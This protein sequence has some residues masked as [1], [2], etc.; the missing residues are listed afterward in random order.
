MSRT[1][2]GLVAVLAL[3]L[4]A[5]T[6]ACGTDSGATTGKQGLSTAVLAE[7]TPVPA[8]RRAR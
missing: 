4:V 7:N 8:L 1:V 6:A 3:F 2:R 5:G